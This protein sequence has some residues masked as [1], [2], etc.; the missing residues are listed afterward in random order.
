M[1][2]KILIIGCGGIGSYL[3]QAVYEL[4][5][6]NQISIESTEIFVAD[7]DT[8][9]I[10]NRNYQNFKDEDIGKF[11]AQVISNRY[12]FVPIVSRINDEKHIEPYN[13]YIIAAD[14]SPV[15]KLVF[16]HCFK[17]DKQFLDLRSEGRNF[18]YFAKGE[19]S[20]LSELCSTLTDDNENGSCQ[21]ID[22]LAKGII[23]LGNQI[24]ALIGCQLLLNIMRDDS[25]ASQNVYAI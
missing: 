25:F 12:G 15:R 19:N 18:A 20:T 2:N 23:Q 10:K 14:N 9:E 17:N 24:I 13:F 3:C 21:R 11:K 16:E 5:L 7:S 1:K 6:K 22:D 4:L 8:V